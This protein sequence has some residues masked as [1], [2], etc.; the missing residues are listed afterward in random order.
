MK[1]LKF[2]DMKAKKKFT[3]D[4]FTIKTKK[5]RKF[6]VAKTPSGSTAWRIMSK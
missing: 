3:T 5:G 4:K 2:Y 6:A 1:K